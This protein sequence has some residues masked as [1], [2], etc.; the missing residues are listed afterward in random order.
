MSAPPPLSLPYAPRRKRPLSVWN[1][2]DYVVLLYWVFFFPQAL[3]WYVETFSRL[4]ADKARWQV[5]REDTIQRCLVLQGM[6]LALGIPLTAAIFLSWLDIEISFYRLALGMAV[7]IALGVARGV[8]R[9]VASGVVVGVAV[10]LALGIVV[11]VA[12]SVTGSVI[13]GVRYGIVVG[14]GSGIVVGVVVGV[15]GGVPLGIMRVVVGGVTFYVVSGL[16]Y[17]VM[18]TLGHG[19]TA[20]LVL[21]VTGGA[22]V[23]LLALRSEAFVLALLPSLF[24]PSQHLA[25]T[26]QRCSSIP[27][28]RLRWRLVQR[29]K[30]DWVEGLHEC[31]GLLRYSLQFIPVINAIQHTLERTPLPELLPRV[32]SWCSMSLY[33]WKVVFFQSASLPNSLLKEF[34]EGFSIVPR[35]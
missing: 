11:G 4:S 5:I 20:G 22:V 14:V 33:D 17:G 34:W 7:G 6:I 12:G 32:A 23:I 8:A 30:E 19:V 10:G 2:L 16:V 13:G 28:Y 3:L 25:I 15:I 21:G 26:L 35:R 9:G 18:G 1:P 27:I 24:F 29:L 31:E